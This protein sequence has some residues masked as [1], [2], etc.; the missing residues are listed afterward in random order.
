MRWCPRGP[1]RYLKMGH[2]PA[3][4]LILPVLLVTLINIEA[5]GPGRS[6]AAQVITTDYP[7]YGEN[8]IELMGDDE[9]VIGKGVW[10][11]ITL[12]GHSRLKVLGTVE[13]NGMIKISENATMDIANAVVNVVPPPIG[14]DDNVIRIWDGGKMIVQK[15]SELTV[16]PQPITKEVRM[17]R[18]N[19]SFIELDDNAAF[20]VTDS[21]F[22]AYLPGDAVPEEERVTGGTILVTGYATFSSFNSELNAFLNYSLWDDDTT[23]SVILERWFWMSSQRYGTIHVENST[24]TLHEPGQTIFKPT[25]GMIILKNSRINGNIRPET[26]SNFFI[27]NCEIFNVNDQLGYASI[28][29]AI[30]FNDHAFGEIVNCTIHGQVKIGWSSTNEFLGKADNIV[31]FKKCR[32]DSDGFFAYANTTVILDECT[33]MDDSM[34]M[35]ISENTRIVLK[36]TELH[37]VLVECGWQQTLV[38]IP[39]N[40]SLELDGSRIHRLFSPEADV[41]FN[42]ELRNGSVIDLFDIHFDNE[43]MNKRVTALIE[44]GSS[45]LF[46]NTGSAETDVVLRNSEAPFFNGTGNVTMTIR[47]MVTGGVTLNEKELDGA[48]IRLMNDGEV[49]SRSVSADGRYRAIFDPIV[50]RNSEIVKNLMDDIS[51]EVSYLG[52]NI[53]LPVPIGSDS[54]IDVH[55]QDHEGPSI[56]DIRWE[57]EKWN[58]KE[59]ITVTANIT[60]TGCG[61]VSEVLLEYSIGGGKWM[62]T[63]MFNTNG[64]SYQGI[65][66]RMDIGDDIRLRIVTRDALGNTAVAEGKRFTVG[67]EPLLIGWIAVLIVM[68]TATLLAAL[69]LYLHLRTRRYLK[70]R[71]TGEENMKVPMG[72]IDGNAKSAGRSI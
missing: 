29:E 66:P 11:N 23:V 30:E 10:G 63:T 72:P 58:H 46:N 49:L 43:F 4:M 25:N 59:Y 7:S 5:P 28:H 50:I 13:I 65:L 67:K 70:K 15:G 56:E 39:E 55:L 61:L 60:D 24:V 14:R 8:V 51:I 2:I 22:T 19:A 6:S 17:E 37:E 42:L 57:P 54:I 36:D 45:V 44:N 18:N 40:I 35:E 53:S 47:Y 20:T 48:E 3:V 1:G 34:L 33:F 31:L 62:N 68:A 16:Y 26:I 69:K 38:S 52:L 32:F 64:N 41:T 27:E 9:K 21:I 12:T 71:F